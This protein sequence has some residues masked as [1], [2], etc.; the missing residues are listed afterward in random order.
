MQ[1]TSLYRKEEVYTR[2]QKAPIFEASV[3]LILSPH[4]FL[5]TNRKVFLNHSKK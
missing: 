5:C 3:T 2:Y 1:A 4:P